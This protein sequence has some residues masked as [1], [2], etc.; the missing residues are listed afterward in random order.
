MYLATGVPVP[1]GNPTIM[2]E[3]HVTGFLCSGLEFDSLS[4]SN[5]TY[6]P[7]KGVKTMSRHGRFEVRTNP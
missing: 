4:I 6:S 2:V 5:V 7:F 1:D 3:W